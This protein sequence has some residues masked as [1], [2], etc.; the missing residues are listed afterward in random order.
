[1]TTIQIGTRVLAEDIEDRGKGTYLEP[2][3]RLHKLGVGKARKAKG[4][5]GSS[6]RELL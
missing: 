5:G 4:G 2:E 6:D 3:C 1:M